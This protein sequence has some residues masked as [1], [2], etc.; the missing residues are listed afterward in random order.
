M[1]SATDTLHATLRGRS[2]EIGVTRRSPSRFA[3]RLPR[4]MKARQVLELFATYPQ[5]DGAF[6]ARLRVR[7]PG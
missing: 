1:R 3:V 7:R 2:G 5:G 4:Y 6:G